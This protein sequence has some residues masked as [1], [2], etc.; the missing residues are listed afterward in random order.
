MD[1]AL[2]LS[3][4]SSYPQKNLAKEFE[5]NFNPME[6]PSGLSKATTSKVLS[7]TRDSDDDA[8]SESSMPSK[9]P[10]V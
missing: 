3:T 10:K 4:E 2:G 8:E 5:E 7:Q 6:G 9:V 1:A